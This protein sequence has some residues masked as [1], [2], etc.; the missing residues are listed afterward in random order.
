M[1]R[2]LF[3]M[4][5]LAG[6]VNPAIGVAVE[7]SRQGHDVAWAGAPE[8]LR[9]LA[10]AGARIFP[11]ATPPADAL[12]RP[13][14]CHGY[15][16]LKFLWERVLVPLAAAMEPGVRAAVDAF[17]PDVL[18][19]DQQAVA[20]AVVANRLGLTWA[21]SASTS[22]ELADP[23]A[24]LPKVGEW[25]RGVM[26]ELQERF[27]DPRV[28]EDLRFSRDLVLAFTTEALTGRGAGDRVQ[29]VGPSIQNRIHIDFPWCDLDPD[30]RLV[31]VT[32]GTVNTGARFLSECVAA[33]EARSD[34]LQAVVADP[35]G[36][37]PG[38]SVNV[39]VRRRIPQP[40]LLERAAA[41]I[42]HGGHNTVCEALHHGVPLVVAPIRDDQPIIADQVARAGAGVRLRFARATAA[43]IGPALDAVLGEPGFREGAAAVRESFRDAGGAVTAAA[44]LVQLADR[45]R[46]AVPAVRSAFASN[47]PGISRSR[48]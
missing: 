22:A 25:L 20:G 13:Q 44:S 33:L 6:H 43:Q 23:L 42:C 47:E 15:A 31:L 2:F 39:I 37:L 24:A 7:L 10:G 34:V 32:L 46:E 21:T 3:V 29:F 8:V 28:G 18:V 14:R 40:A 48:R 1:S 5:P 19:V 36:A 41:V 38:S 9:P 26:R 16:A 27:G 4:P 11:C 12:V 30:R 17:A 45:A 35:A